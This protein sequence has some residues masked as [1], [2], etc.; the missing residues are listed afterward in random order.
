MNQRFKMNHFD[1]VLIGFKI[2]HIN[3][4]NCQNRALLI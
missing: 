2:K 3:F 4:E 1:S